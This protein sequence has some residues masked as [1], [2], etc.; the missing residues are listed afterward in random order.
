[1]SMGPVT[2]GNTTTSGMTITGTGNADPFIT[3]DLTATN[4][5]SAAV[6]FT[7]NFSMPIW[8]DPVDTDRISAALQVILNSGSVTDTADGIPFFS[9]WLGRTDN[10]WTNQG[11][12]LNGT[13]S[14]G[15]VPVTLPPPPISLTALTPPVYPMDTYVQFDLSAGGSVELIGRAD[16]I[17]AP[18]PGSLICWA[19]LGFVLAG[20]YSWRRRRTAA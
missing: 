3:F 7:F 18:E 6:E 11:V 19:G 2:V 20:T 16:L 14:A 9:T 17:H 10:G 13:G 8:P 15:P 4:N 1:M 12:D 5:T